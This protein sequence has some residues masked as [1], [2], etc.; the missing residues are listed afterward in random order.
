[1]FFTIMTDET[2]TLVG[3][4]NEKDPTRNQGNLQMFVDLGER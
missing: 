3:G 4:E 2:A 1:M